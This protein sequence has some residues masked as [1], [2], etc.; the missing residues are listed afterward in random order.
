MKG[1]FDAASRDA[2]K[3]DGGRSR[4]AAWIAH[5][6]EFFNA[7]AVA[8][9]GEGLE[10]PESGPKTLTLTLEHGAAGLAS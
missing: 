3:F 6:E 9:S 8:L 2:L 4:H 1:F 5:G 10:L 7:D